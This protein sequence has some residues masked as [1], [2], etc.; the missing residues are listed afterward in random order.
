MLAQRVMT[1][2][3]MLIV[4]AAAMAAPSAWPF[5]A[6]MALVTG[7]CGF[8]WLRLTGPAG[9]ARGP[10]AGGV[11]LFIV[12][13]LLA[14]YWVLAPHGD[15]ADL[16]Y[17]IMVSIVVPAAALLWIVAAAPAVVRG[18]SDAPAPSAGL[19]FFAIP[20]LLAAWTVLA[21]LFVL[22]GPW[23]VLSLLA[24]VWVA[25]IAAYFGGR[26]LGKHKLAPRVSP[27]KTVEGA[28]CGIAAAVAW[29]GVSSIWNGS[30]GHALAQRWT[31]PGALLAAVLLAAL[32]IVGD[33]FESLLKRRAGRK[34]SSALLPGHGGVY[35]RI[36]A[37]LPVA[38]VALLLSGVLF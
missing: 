24:L 37:V 27:G 25:D 34:D 35:D 22:R 38:P 1:A 31:L 18:R 19:S 14:R 15:T 32:S 20:A 26:A 29:I 6:L 3:V 2:V 13:L 5:L 9:S 21:L 10:I 4:L 23:F 30:F 7:C 33:L 36:D 17:L 16:L 12:A 8:E 28:V 11:A